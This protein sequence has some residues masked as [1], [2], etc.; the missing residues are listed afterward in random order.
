RKFSV[1]ER[2]STELLITRALAGSWKPRSVA[3]VA[4]MPG[5]V[6]S[7]SCITPQRPSRITTVRITAIGQERKVL[8]KIE[9]AM[10]STAISHRIIRLLTRLNA[11][12]CEPVTSASEPIEPISG[13]GAKRPTQWPSVLFRISTSKL[14]PSTDLAGSEKYA[15]RLD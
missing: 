7:P 8:Q 6:E 5:A 13:L 15:G 3:I 1:R 4:P 2:A 14:P 10:I 12:G 11:N 9:I